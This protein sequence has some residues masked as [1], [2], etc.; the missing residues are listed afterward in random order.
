MNSKSED[1]L[2]ITP[3]GKFKDVIPG[4]TT[5]VVSHANEINFNISPTESVFVFDS[6]LPGGNTV[7]KRIVIYTNNSIA[8]TIFKNG[9]ALLEK[10]EKDLKIEIPLTI[11][12][13]DS[14]KNEWHGSCCTRLS[15]QI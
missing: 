5:I 12:K 2:I 7:L 8:K 14:E 4:L 10:M 9:M 6:S 1:N 11:E 13:Q 3:G 15:K